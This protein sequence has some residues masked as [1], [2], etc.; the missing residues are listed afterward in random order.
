MKLHDVELAVGNIIK[1]F[2]AIHIDHFHVLI[3]V[4]ILTKSNIKKIFETQKIVITN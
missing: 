1:I 3:L 4:R 2:D